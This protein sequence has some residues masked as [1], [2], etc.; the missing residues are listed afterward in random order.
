MFPVMPGNIDTVMS[1][2]NGTQNSR[3]TA[4]KLIKIPSL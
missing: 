2:I 1:A 3:N 4:K